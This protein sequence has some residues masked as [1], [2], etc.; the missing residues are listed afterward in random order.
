MARAYAPVYDHDDERVHIP[1]DAF[2]F[3]GFQRWVESDEFPESGRI[4]FLAGEVEVDLSPE[5]L[6]TH[7]AV[8]FAVGLTLGDLLVRTGLADIQ[9][10]R[11]RLRSRLAGLSA[12]PD[13]IVLFKETLTSGRAKLVPA[14]RRKGPNRYIAVEGAADVVVEIISDSSK[15]KDTQDLPPLYARAGI[16]ERW[17]VDARG[18]SLRFEIWTLRNGVYKLQP[19]D[20]EGWVI[21]PRLGRAFRLIRFTDPPFPWRYVLEHRD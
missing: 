16:L 5:D 15:K 12:E 17:I 7:G 4:D 9:T 20:A 21:S 19:T 3:E 13:L 14:S 1:M 8:K 11:A 6:Y 2:T 10:D 18:A